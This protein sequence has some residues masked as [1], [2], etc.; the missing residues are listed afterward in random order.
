MVRVVIGHLTEAKILELELL[1]SG[2]AVGRPTVELPARFRDANGE[3]EAVVVFE[4]EPRKPLGFSSPGEGEKKTA[5]FARRLAD[6][7]TGGT[8][9]VEPETDAPCNEQ[10]DQDI[11]KFFQEISD[12]LDHVNKA[13]DA[14]W[15]IGPDRTAWRDSVETCREELLDFQREL[16]ER[17][18]G[19]E[20]EQEERV[21]K[22][23][24][25]MQSLLPDP[26]NAC[27]A[28]EGEIFEAYRKVCVKRETDDRSPER[29]A[30]DERIAAEPPLPPMDTPT[31]PKAIGRPSE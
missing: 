14:A 23:L 25:E 11:A 2:D 27:N 9:P 22:E 24:A 12:H 20:E 10:P 15:F 4:R 8:A 5:E 28:S 16:V 26:T 13:I 3:R 7:A 30:Q 17:Y 19:T 1:L 18:A 6:V 21:Q 31:I 29:R